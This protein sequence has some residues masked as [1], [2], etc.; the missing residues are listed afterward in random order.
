MAIVQN[1]LKR[2][3]SGTR[4]QADFIGT[5]VVKMLYA[6]VLYTVGHKKCGTLL[7]S[8]SSPIHDRF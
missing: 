3:V 7:L 4:G 1:K 8:I 2:K 6:L 5:A